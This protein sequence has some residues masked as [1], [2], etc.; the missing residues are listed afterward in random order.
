MTVVW[1]GIESGDDNSSD[2]RNDDHG[3][4]EDNGGDGDDDGSGYNK[5]MIVG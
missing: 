2:G 5:V 1:K 3:S 4:G